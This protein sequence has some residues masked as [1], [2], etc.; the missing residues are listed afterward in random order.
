[1]KGLGPAKGIFLD[2]LKIS[3]VSVGAQAILRRYYQGVLITKEPQI[4]KKLLTYSAIVSHF[5]YPRDQKPG[6]TGIRGL[7]NLMLFNIN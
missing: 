1:M 2:S 3:G 4:E 7:A 5:R 6:S